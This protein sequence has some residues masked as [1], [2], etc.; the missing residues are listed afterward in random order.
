ME[1]QPA[2]SAATLPGGV[3]AADVLGFNVAMPVLAAGAMAAGGLVACSPFRPP[4]RYAAAAGALTAAWFLAASTAATRLVFE[5]SGL[6]RYAWLTEALGAPPRRWVNLTTG[7]DDTTGTLARLW[8]HSRYLACDRFDP[9]APHEP[10][11]LRARAIRPPR[12][13]TVEPGRSLPIESA[14]VDA[15][16][17]LMAAHE[18]RDP[19]ARGA[20]FADAARVLGPGGRLVVVEH[21]RDLANAAAF[22][23]GV[24]HFSP[25]EVWRRAGRG[26]GLR[27]VSEARRTPFVRAFVFE[28][29]QVRPR[30]ATQPVAE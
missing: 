9:A 1:L 8:P 28:R 17:L 12:G 26:A 7:F 13:V 19:A 24:L 11:L 4:I 5:R 27:L 6:T 22:G 23:P 3:T 25:P 21:A 14:S 30:R 20:L 29:Q 18:V 2:A 16:F 15:V 10:A